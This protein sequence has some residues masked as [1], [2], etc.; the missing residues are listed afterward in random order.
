MT[1]RTLLDCT[2]TRNNKNKKIAI[3]NAVKPTVFMS[4]LLLFNSVDKASPIVKLREKLIKI[5]IP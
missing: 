1:M 2:N 4:R 3:K 5:L